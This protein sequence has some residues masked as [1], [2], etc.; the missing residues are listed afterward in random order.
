MHNNQ[1]TVEYIL[2]VSN[3]EWFQEVE[4]IVLL[5]NQN[6]QNFLIW[7]KLCANSVNRGSTQKLERNMCYIN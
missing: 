5:H 3:I 2:N 4:N 7:T 6:V 1:W